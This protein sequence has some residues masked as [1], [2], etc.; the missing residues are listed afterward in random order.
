[1]AVCWLFKA[2][3]VSNLIF[4]INIFF[5]KIKANGRSTHTKPDSNGNPFYEAQRNKKIGV[6]SGTEF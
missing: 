4:L 2:A 5:L 6:D 3:V 1:M